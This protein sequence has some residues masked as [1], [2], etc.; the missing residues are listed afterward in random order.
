MKDQFLSKLLAQPWHGTAVRNRA[1]IGGILSRLRS[2]RPEEDVYGN[3]LPKMQ[4]VGDVAIIPIRGV[5][6]IGIPQWL[7]EWGCNVTDANDI[8]DEL[9]AAVANANVGLIVLDCDSPG[10]WSVAGDKLFDLVE[11]AA[12]RKPV[13]GWVADGNDCCSSCYE[14]AAPARA[15]LAG[16][17]ALAIG[18]IGSYLAMLDD[19]EYWKMLG[20]TWEIFRSGDFKGMGDDKLTEEQRGWLQS[21][22]DTFGARFRKNVAKYRTEIPEEEMQ[23]QYYSGIDAARLGFTGGTAADLSTAI[24][25]FRRML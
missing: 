18:C 21:Q 16:R 8:A 1:L 19:T 15:I 7:K 14:A 13:F 10:G 22:V 20:F 5:L 25:K 3:P 12:R 24:A 2:D 6:M 23:G 4:V 11:A 9:D 17:H